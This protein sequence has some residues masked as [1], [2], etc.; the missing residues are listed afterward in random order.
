LVSSQDGILSKFGVE[1]RGKKNDKTGRRRNM[2]T[3]EILAVEKIDAS[4]KLLLDREIGKAGSG[5][6]A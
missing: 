5:I 1:T 3:K 4:E 2:K 6:V